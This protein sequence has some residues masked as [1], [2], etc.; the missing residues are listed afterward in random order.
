VIALG[1]NLPTYRVARQAIPHL[2]VARV[3]ERLLPIACLSIAALLAFA[4]ARARPWLVALVLV[5]VAVD[6]H[7]PL[8]HAANADEGNAAYAAIEGPSR[9][10][11]L[12]VFLPDVNLNSTYLYYDLAARRERPLGY[13]TLVPRP[14]F[15]T[16]RRLRS[17]NCG[18]WSGDVTRLGVRDIVVHGPLFAEFLPRCRPK[19][20]AALRAHGFR[21]VAADGDVV[22]WSA[23][24]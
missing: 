11:E 2:D 8:Y 15:R 24:P 16:A 14:A 18:T 13:S 10:L 12:P 23:R 22:L 19:A 1:T 17:L 4:L 20:E 7:V 21:R 3:P 5:L 9:L 6:L